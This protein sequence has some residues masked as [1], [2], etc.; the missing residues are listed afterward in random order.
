MGSLLA[1]FWDAVRLYVSKY[2]MTLRNDVLL[3]LFEVRKERIASISG[4]VKLAFISRIVSVSVL[5]CHG[6]N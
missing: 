5:Q 1:G 3:H 6:F 4:L 2:R